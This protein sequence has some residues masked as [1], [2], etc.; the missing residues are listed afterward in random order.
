M[1]ERVNEPEEPDDDFFNLEPTDFELEEIE[2]LDDLVDDP[3][4]YVLGRLE[5]EDTYEGDPL[6]LHNK[7]SFKGIRIA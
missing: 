6:D 7:I 3:I 4:Q 5:F 2:A 1:G